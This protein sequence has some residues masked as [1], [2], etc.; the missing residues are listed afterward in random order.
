MFIGFCIIYL[1]LLIFAD[2]ANYHTGRIKVFRESTVLKGSGTGGQSISVRTGSFNTQNGLAYIAHP[3]EW[4][5]MD[6]PATTS[7]VTYTVKANTGNAS[8]ATAINRSVQRAQLENDD[9]AYI[10]T[11]DLYEVAQ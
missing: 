5:Y 8:Y 7:Q 2:H 6:S 4:R 11:L 3:W 1:N 10:T 9:A